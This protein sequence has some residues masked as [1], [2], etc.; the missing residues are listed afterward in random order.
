MVVNYILH[1]FITTR[2]LIAKFGYGKYTPTW[3]LT[4]S[5]SVK[6]LVLHYIFQPLHLDTFTQLT[7]SSGLHKI[8]TESILRTDWTV[9]SFPCDKSF[10]FLHLADLFRNLILEFHPSNCR[11][12][13]LKRINK[14]SDINILFTLSLTMRNKS[15][16]CNLL[17]ELYHGA[18][19][20]IEPMMYTV[21][22]WLI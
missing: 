1:H 5:V 12:L 4:S 21:P 2:K 19:I 16:I 20:T 10:T 8:M 3:I 17:D 22:T 11:I 13:S 6:H 7:R 9:N 15:M 18:K 14:K